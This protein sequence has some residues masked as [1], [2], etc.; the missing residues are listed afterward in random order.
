[1]LRGLNR[2]QRQ[3]IKRVLLSRDYTL[4]VGE[5]MTYDI[6][7]VCHI[8]ATK[9]N[10]QPCC[11]TDCEAGISNVKCLSAVDCLVLLCFIV[12]LPYFSQLLHPYCI[13]AF[14]FFLDSV[15]RLFMLFMLCMFLRTK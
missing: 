9:H 4:I 8:V 7:S 12:F 10:T 6:C 13:Y 3:A 5:L 2:T 14:M 11:L 15:L 1:M